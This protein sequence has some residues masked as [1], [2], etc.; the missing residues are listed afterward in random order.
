MD[1]TYFNIEKNAEKLRHYIRNCLV[2]DVK[3]FLAK[4]KNELYITDYLF[5]SDEYGKCGFQ[6]AI[7]YAEYHEYDSI[8][9]FDIL[10]NY[11]ISVGDFWK[12]YSLFENGDNLLMY[13]VKYGKNRMIV[14]YL[15]HKFN[16]STESQNEDYQN[17]FHFIAEDKN[18]FDI[19]YDLL[20][21]YSEI[22]NFYE[23]DI[24]NKT[25]IDYAVENNNNE[26]LIELLKTHPLTI[27]IIK[28]KIKNTETFKPCED[29]NKNIKLIENYIFKNEDE[30]IDKIKLWCIKGTKKEFSILIAYYYNNNFNINF[31]EIINRY[32]ILLYL[33]KSNPSNLKYKIKQLIEVEKLDLNI[34]DE[35]QNT[36]LYYLAKNNHTFIIKFLIQNY[37]L[38]FLY[39]DLD[40]FSENVK[41]CLKEIRI[42]KGFLTISEIVESNIVPDS[43]PFFSTKIK[44][45]LNDVKIFDTIELE[46]YTCKEYLDKDKN[47]VIFLNGANNDVF[48]FNL[49]NINN[50]YEVLYLDCKRDD[51]NNYI[52]HKNDNNEV[53]GVFPFYE[54]VPKPFND[55][56][57][58][59]SLVS[60]QFY[61]LFKD[62]LSAI[63]KNIRIFKIGDPILNLKY[64]TSYKMNYGMSLHHG[65]IGTEK[66][67]HELSVCI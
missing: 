63:V 22:E 39:L 16:F 10:I 51:N 41:K 25:P 13:A 45:N 64:T 8:D 14:D 50:I 5:M 46:T 48:S 12:I 7:D 43:Y 15:L 11:C 6:I 28:E 32:K 57:V 29:L 4:N 58:K 67:I 9:L 55:V 20:F 2:E 38:E 44:I 54:N 42:S 24:Y 30:F 35:C 21:E 60:G 40:L 34:K 37:D 65:Q 1:D 62:F 19:Y 61:F 56:Y 18:A 36:I 3:M 27:D 52:E 59:I 49:Q 66:V 33:C 47:N 53:C 17:V 31:S 26:M 23:N